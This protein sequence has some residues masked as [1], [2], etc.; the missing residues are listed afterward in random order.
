MLFVFAWSGCAQ[1]VQPKPFAP[2]VARMA[3]TP[4][5]VVD[6]R[7]KYPGYLG[8][9]LTPEQESRWVGELHLLKTETVATFVGRVVGAHRADATV[10]LL[11]FN[12]RKTSVGLTSSV[13]EARISAEVTTPLE[14]SLISGVGNLKADASQ[15]RSHEIAVEKALEQFIAG[16]LAMK[17]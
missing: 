10:K 16:L 13:I 1:F 12:C 8:M 9:H 2:T 15:L 4:V 5:P 17:K 6:A 3:G 11:E 7:P 14:Q